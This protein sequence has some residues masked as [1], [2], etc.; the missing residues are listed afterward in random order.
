[1][2]FDL[3]LAES[4]FRGLLLSA[5]SII[6][7]IVL[8]RVNGLRTFSK[9]TNF[10]FA[11]TIA[12]GSLIASGAQASTWTSFVQILAAILGLVLVQ[13]VTAIL[14]RSSDQFSR[15]V[16][17]L[18]VILMR[19]GVI[20]EEALRHTRVARDELIAKLRE[21][22]VHDIAQVRAV[23]LEKTGDISVLHGETLHDALLDGSADIRRKT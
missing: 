18:P 5:A 23:V 21:A 3:P 19:D 8:V 11:M 4:V 17:N 15:I 2:L 12:V 16:Q 6:W 13:R 7:V 10:D 14:C 9:M 20:V 1:M 22:N